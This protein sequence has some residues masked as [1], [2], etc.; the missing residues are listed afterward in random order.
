[1]AA[2]VSKTVASRAS[3]RAIEFPT[4]R[5]RLGHNLGTHGS[6]GRRQKACLPS[7]LEGIPYG[8]LAANRCG[9]Q[10]FRRMSGRTTDQN[11]VALPLP[12]TSLVGRAEEIAAARSLLLDEAVPLLTLTGPGGV[13][14]TRLALQ[15]ATDLIDAFADGTIF[16]DLTPIRD[17]DLVLAAIGQVIDVRE[18]GNRSLAEQIEAFLKPRQVLLLLDNFEQ[19]IDAA[20]IVADL[21]IACPAVQVLATSRA[22]LRVRGEHLLPVPPLAIPDLVTAPEV[23]DLARCEAV[24]LFVQRVRA[25]DPSF[26]LTEDNATAVASICTHLDGLPLALE[27]AA[28]RARVLPPAMLVDRLDHSLAFLT[29]GA[30]DQPER[31]RTMRDAIAWSYDLLTTD[32]Q[33]LFSRL[34]VFAGGFTFDAVAAVA[35][36]ADT[37]ESG[38]LD[39]MTTLV[40]ASLVQPVEGD[41]GD[42]RFEML[43]TIRE[44]AQEL[45]DASEEEAPARRA[46]AAHFLD[47]AEESWQRTVLMFEPGGFNRL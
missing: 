6:I 43:E 14:K 40:D 20:P 7:A 31:L 25:V 26:D 8:D 13:G 35:G 34:A 44:F 17:P 45:L 22:P 15:V 39:G 24:A 9:R 37:A 30:R 23:D 2:T 46:H 5:C 1:M 36:G 11:A 3:V 18:T 41:T 29:G 4:R 32:E 27:L 16:V 12:R 47:I 28:A 21:L 19:V 42:L 33:R 10:P 38:L